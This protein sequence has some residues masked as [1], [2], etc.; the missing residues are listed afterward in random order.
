MS[1]RQLAMIIDLN[2]CIGC[3]TCTVACKT[4]W[5]N[6]D[7]REYMYWNSVESHPGRGYPKNWIELGGGFDKDGNLK[8]GIVPNIQKD[9]G[10]PWDFNY[11]EISSQNLLPNDDG[12]PKKAGFHPNI[13]P[14]WSPNWDEDDGSG[15][16]PND[17]YLFYIPRICNHCTEPSCLSA[18]PRDAIFKRDE[19]GVVLVDLDRCQGY[20]YCIA[21]C[22]Y[23]KIYFNP[24]IS[25]SEKCNMCFPLIEQGLPPACA[26]QCVGRTRFV[27]FLDDEEGQVFQLVYRYKV[28][29]PLLGEY[30]TQPNVYYIPPME[31]P[32]K[33]DAFGNTIKG[34]QRLPMAELE[35]LFGADVH[36]VI[37]LLKE[38]RE[39]QKS[40][41]KSEI[42]EL[43]IS[44]QHAD[45]FRLDS[46]YYKQVAKERG[47]KPYRQ[48]DDRYKQGKYT[49]RSKSNGDKK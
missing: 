26:K 5:T 40:G 3:Q 33:Y 4:E 2:K 47:K 43:L 13:E 28:A 29:L 45:M 8:D 27:G 18:C 31:A 15:D 24:K 21:G 17:N 14:S 1:K 12:T 25:K 36:R 7:G 11:D 19:D 9:Y 37:N 34:S 22:P 20:R 38:E 41:E 46:D 49:K 23:K 10:T 35:R 30:G 6:R 48:L 39:K 42:L 32:P 44:Y 16:F